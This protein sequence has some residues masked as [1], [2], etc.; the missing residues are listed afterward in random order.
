LNVLPA[1]N[2][3]QHKFQELTKG[4]RQWEKSWLM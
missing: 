2:S 1:P 4:I 3:K